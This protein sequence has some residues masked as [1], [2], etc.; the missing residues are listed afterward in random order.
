M[1]AAQA[2]RCGVIGL[3]LIGQLHASILASIGDVDLV[4][5]VDTDPKRTSACP[6]GTRFEAEAAAVVD[7]QLDA[8]VVATPEH[9]HRGPVE[10]ALGTGAAV[11]CEKPFASSLEDADAM[12]GAAEASGRPLLVAHTLR[13]DPRYR[14]VH[15]AV[16]R[17]ELGSV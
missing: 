13:F 10:L 12:I 11:L 3:G 17:G 9:L 7:A 2:L 8:V 14:A 6:K 16:T 4:L 1:S 5:C 15:E